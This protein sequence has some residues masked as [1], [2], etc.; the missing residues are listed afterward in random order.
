MAMKAEFVSGGA[1][2]VPIEQTA[3]SKYSFSGAVNFVIKE[4]RLRKGPFGAL[5]YQGLFEGKLGTALDQ[6]NLRDRSDFEKSFLNATA[7]FF[8]GERVPT[9]LSDK[10]NLQAKQISKFTAERCSLL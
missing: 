4:A 3:D 8:L 2:M 7:L 5:K 10:V 6:M 1:A 9:D